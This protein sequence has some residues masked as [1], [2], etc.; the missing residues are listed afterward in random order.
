[1]LKLVLLSLN[2]LIFKNLS[3]SCYVGMSHIFPL[4]VVK[5][6]LASHIGRILHQGF[7]V[8]SGHLQLL[9]NN[10]SLRFF[11]FGS[12]PILGGLIHNYLI[13]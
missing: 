7:E 9:I 1:M 6:M 2:D 3:F 8:L 13:I 5:E 4:I 12:S 10:Y 11:P